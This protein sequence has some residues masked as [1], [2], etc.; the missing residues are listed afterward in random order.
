MDWRAPGP[1]NSSFHPEAAEQPQQVTKCRAAPGGSFRRTRPRAECRSELGLWTSGSSTTGR[2]RDADSQAPPRPPTP[3]TQGWAPAIHVLRSP[4]G[5]SDADAGLDL[6]S[7]RTGVSDIS[8]LHARLGAPRAGLD[9]YFR[10]I[11]CFHLNKGSRLEQYQIGFDFSLI[12]MP[13]CSGPRKV[14]L[15]IPSAISRAAA[16]ETHVDGVPRSHLCTRQVTASCPAQPYRHTWQNQKPVLG[17]ELDRCD[18]LQSPGAPERK[19]PTPGPH[20]GIAAKCH[21]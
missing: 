21:L 13:S 11:V 5:D 17:A 20:S 19:T 8:Q 1:R 18:Q 6:S 2:G 4:P 15:E 10:N 9:I 7:P 16:A 12:K 14:C 3:D